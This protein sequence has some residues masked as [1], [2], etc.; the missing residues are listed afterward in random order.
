MCGLVSVCVRVEQ[1]PD[2]RIGLVWDCWAALMACY[3]YQSAQSMLC[4]VG[5]D[6]GVAQRK[7]RGR[8]EMGVRARA[9]E[10]VMSE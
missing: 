2:L 5:C 8:T 3:S 7:D 6:M 9:S 10:R 4:W 1:G